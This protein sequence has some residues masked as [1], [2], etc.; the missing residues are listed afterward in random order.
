MGV[1]ILLDVVRDDA[2]IARERELLRIERLRHAAS[3]RARRAGIPVRRTA[4]SSLPCEQLVHRPVAQRRDRH[5]MILG[6]RSVDQEDEVIAV[7][8]ELRPA[9]RLLARP[10]LRQRLRRSRRSRRRASTGR[11]SVALK[12]MTPAAFHVAPLRDRRRVADELRRSAGGRDSLQLSVGE[13]PDRLSVRRPERLNGAIGAGERVAAPRSSRRR[14]QSDCA[15]FLVADEARPSCRRAR[16]PPDRSSR[17]C[18]G[19]IASGNVIRGSDLSRG[20]HTRAI[21]DA[22]ANGEQPRSSRTSTAIARVRDGAL[23]RCRGFRRSTPAPARCRARS[24]SAR[25]DLSRGTSRRRARARAASA[26]AARDRLR[27]AR[28]RSRR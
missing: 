3:R 11:C 25:P 16:A 27:L 2:R 4:R 17:P 9:M 28:R 13:E 19:G 21:R 8:K 5:V 26:A 14:T 15:L 1:G 23:S 7:G 20:Q 24:A 18:R 10:Q 6:S 12:T 22:S